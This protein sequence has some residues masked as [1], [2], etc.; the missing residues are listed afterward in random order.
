[1]GRR[2]F[3]ELSG[4][5]QRTAPVDAEWRF[6]RF[7]V[8]ELSAGEGTFEQRTDKLKTLASDIIVPVKRQRFTSNAELR[9]KLKPVRRRP[10]RGRDAAPR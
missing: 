7:H 1:M 9:A 8:F 3:D 10:R 4:A 5:V 2:R 6:I